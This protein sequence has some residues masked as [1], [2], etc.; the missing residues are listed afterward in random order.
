MAADPF[1]PQ[2]SIKKLIVKKKNVTLEKQSLPQKNI[3]EP[4][5]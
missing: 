1:P 5:I 4:V 3:L 2:T